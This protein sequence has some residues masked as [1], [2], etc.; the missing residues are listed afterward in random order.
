MRL[1]PD[2]QTMIVVCL[3]LEGTAAE[4]H[5]T[6]N[7]IGFSNCL[8]LLRRAWIDLPYLP[9]KTWVLEAGRFV[10]GG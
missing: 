7:T 6:D 4:K 5:M 8:N 2:K 9:L 1:N 10:H 3:A